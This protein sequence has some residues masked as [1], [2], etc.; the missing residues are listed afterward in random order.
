MADQDEK[1]SGVT[2]NPG[3]RWLGLDEVIHPGFGHTTIS[4]DES[5]FTLEALCAALES[6]NLEDYVLSLPRQD[7]TIS[8][9]ETIE[10]FREAALA[11]LFR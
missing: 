4:L 5:A 6:G 11:Y 3:D 8:N 1:P 9:K 2:V 10:K 7:L